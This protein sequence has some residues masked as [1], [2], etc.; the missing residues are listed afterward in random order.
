MDLYKNKNFNVLVIV[1][2]IVLFMLLGTI[3]GEVLGIGSYALAS[4]MLVHVLF[5]TGILIAYI[6]ILLE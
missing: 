1:L 5:M 3:A 6:I 2:G 4:I